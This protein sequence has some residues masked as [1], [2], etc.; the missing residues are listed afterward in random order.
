MHVLQV[1][2]S[3]VLGGIE[4]VNCDYA[5]LLIARGHQVTLL[6]R[7]EAESLSHARSTGAEIL[8]DRVAVQ[9]WGGFNPWKWAKYRRLIH[10]RC[11]DAVLMHNGKAERLFSRASRGLCPV[12]GVSHN[13]NFQ[14]R[15]RMDGVFCVNSRMRELFIARAGALWSDRPAIVMPNPLSMSI[16]PPQPWIPNVFKRPFVMGTLCRMVSKKGLHLLI[17]AAAQL[18]SSGRDFRI[19]MGGDGIERHALELLRD[20]R[21]LRNE[22]YFPGWIQNRLQFFS[23]IDVF[24]LPS[25]IEPFGL[26]LTEAMFCGRPVVTS[27]ADGPWDIVRP[28]ETGLMVPRGEAAALATAIDRLMTNPELGI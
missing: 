6:M 4:Q 18:K 13:D 16:K 19:V 20:Q 28:E 5:K 14:S 26:V 15:A 8:L 9:P 22:V 11:V 21:G 23:E 25:T 3:A 12:I 17:E 1:L 10:D 7:P 2:S 27:D 24:C